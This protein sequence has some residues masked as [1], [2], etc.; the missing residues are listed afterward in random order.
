MNGFIYDKGYYTAVIPESFSTTI[1]QSLSTPSQNPISLTDPSNVF[2]LQNAVSDN[3]NRFQITYSRYMRCQDPTASQ[4]VNDPPC[5]VDGQDNFINLNNAYQ[6]LLTSIQDLSGSYATQTHLDS[7]TPYNYDI[8][9]AE[10][11]IDYANLVKLRHEL[12]LKLQMLQKQLG[13][14][15]DT[16]TKRLESA[17]FA[18]TMWVIL[19]S[20]LVY[21]IV[22][23]L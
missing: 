23:E 13:N 7:K 15:T 6:S 4:Q 1:T 10:I 3:L 14:G 21:Y 18:N 22:I 17:I 12:D 20:C 9:A 19:A 2:Q 16:S 11:P 8:S 5:S